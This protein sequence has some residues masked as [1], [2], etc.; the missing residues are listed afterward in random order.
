MHKH[1]WQPER[2]CYQVGRSYRAIHHEFS[3]HPKKGQKHI[4]RAAYYLHQHHCTS[5]A[6]F[7]SLLAQTEHG[8]KKNLNRGHVSPRTGRP[9]KSP[10]A[11][12]SKK[13]PEPAFRH[14]PCRADRAT[15]PN[16]PRG[17]HRARPRGPGR[18]RRPRP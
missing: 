10:S 16:S 18:R 9:T 6:W 7:L 15:G 17:S 1:A 12:K 2:S 8:G 13:Q 3:G 14:H 5:T 11:T 4:R